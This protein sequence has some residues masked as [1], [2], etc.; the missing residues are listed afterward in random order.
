M[1]RAKRMGR[2][3][4]LIAVTALVGG[5]PAGAEIDPGSGL[6]S[7]TPLVTGNYTVTVVVSDTGGL[8]DT[9]FSQI[10]VVEDGRLK[11]YLPVVTKNY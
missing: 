6:F 11:I 3:L 1:R 10:E 8:T 7:W 9:T 2:A 5:E 4:V